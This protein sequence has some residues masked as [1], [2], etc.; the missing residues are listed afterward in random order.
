MPTTL[1]AGRSSR[2]RPIPKGIRTSRRNSP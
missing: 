2:T 1:S